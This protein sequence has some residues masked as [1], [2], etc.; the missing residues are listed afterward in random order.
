MLLIGILSSYS[1]RESGIITFAQ[2]AFGIVVF[3][4]L[5]AL[6]VLS[7]YAVCQFRSSGTE[8]NMAVAEL[9]S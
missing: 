3:V 1:A 4:S 8:A 2:F 7:F 6:Y 5:G 9:Q